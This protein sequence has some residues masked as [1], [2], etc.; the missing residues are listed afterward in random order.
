MSAEVEI[1]FLKRKLPTMNIKWELMPAVGQI[2]SASISEDE[3]KKIISNL[4][5]ALL[6]KA[7]VNFPKMVFS[8]A[9][10]LRGGMRVVVVMSLLREI[11]GDEMADDSGGGGKSYNPFSTKPKPPGRGI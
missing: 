4:R 9:S 2:I 10:K 8:V 3:A 11:F 1:R 5:D 6:K 7:G